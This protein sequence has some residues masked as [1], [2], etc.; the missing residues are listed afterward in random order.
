MKITI[1]ER[2]MQPSRELQ[3]YALSKVQHLEHYFEGI[4]SVEIILDEE[5]ERKICEL[6][7]HFV[8][9]KMVMAK[10]VADDFYAAIDAAV[11]KL[12]KQVLR[13]KDKL[14]DTR[15]TGKELEALQQQRQEAASL[16]GDRDREP[17]LPDVIRTPVPLGKPMTVEE[18][19]LQLE[20]SDKRDVLIFVDAERGALSVLHRRPDG[21]YELLEPET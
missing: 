18:A 10:A 17:R 20:A 12:K 16:G 14:Q 7:A 2:H 9:R 13:F 4:V 8:R 1:T 11:D 5:K 21:K 6:V 15:L 19:I 3:E